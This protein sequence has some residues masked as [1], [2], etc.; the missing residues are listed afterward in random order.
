MPDEVILRRW[1]GTVPTERAQQYAQYMAD[2]GRSFVILGRSRAQ[3]RR[4]P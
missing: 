2:T 4:R 1:T 3:R